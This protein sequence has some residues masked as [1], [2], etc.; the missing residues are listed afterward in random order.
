[1]PEKVKKQSKLARFFK[2]PEDPPVAWFGPFRVFKG[3][4]IEK[5]MGDDQGRHSLE[6]ATIALDE[7][8][9]L[10]KRVTLTRVVATGLF[11]LALKKKKGG[12]KWLLFA[13]QDFEWLEEVPLKKHAEALKFVQ[14]AQKIQR[15]IARSR[16]GGEN[17]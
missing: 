9:E 8:T 6:G 17:A 4:D 3:G 15:D 2:G 5:F 14:A 11:A 16:A 10:S 1:M 12:E 13:G 7:G